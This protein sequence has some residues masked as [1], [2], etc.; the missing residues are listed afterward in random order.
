MAKHRFLLIFLIIDVFI[1]FCLKTKQN[2]TFP[3]PLFI[4]LF[5][6]QYRFMSYFI[7]W[8]VI[9]IYL[10]LKFSQI[11]SVGAPSNWLLWPSRRHDCHSLYTS[12]HS[13][14]AGCSKH[15]CKFPTPGP[16]P[17]LSP[18]SPG[19]LHVNNHEVCSWLLVRAGKHIC[20]NVNTWGLSWWSSG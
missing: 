13:G 10:I 6:Y 3:S 4:Y 11:W 19:S 5:N 18:R 8:V 16:E 15:T 14:R 1:I 2:K 17:A 12:S 7:L 9:M 20:I